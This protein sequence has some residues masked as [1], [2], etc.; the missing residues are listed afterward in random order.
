M[1][2]SC[3]SLLFIGAITWP[4][5]GTL[6]A[7][8]QSLTAMN[9]ETLDAESFKATL[10]AENQEP[11]VIPPAAN[12]EA[13]SARFAPT[14]FGATAGGASLMLGSDLAGGLIYN[15]PFQPSLQISVSRS[16]LARQGL[17]GFRFVLVHPQARRICV[18]EHRARFWQEGKV[19]T[20]E[21]LPVRESGPSGL[22]VAFKIGTRAP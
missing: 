18:A 13:W 11:K 7:A 19:V 22:P 6:H 10:G 4:M 3:L 2:R 16:L 15:G 14:G 20:I 21:L 5:S 12:A 9:C 1:L 8:R 17:D